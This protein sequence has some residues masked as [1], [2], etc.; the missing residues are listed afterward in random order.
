AGKAVADRAVKVVKIPYEYA[1]SMLQREIDIHSF[2]RVSHGGDYHPNIVRLDYVLEE[3][4]VFTLVMAAAAAREA[5]LEVELAT[6]DNEHQNHQRWLEQ[7]VADLDHFA[8]KHPQTNNSRN[9]DPTA[10]PVC[11]LAE[12]EL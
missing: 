7:C 6:R 11:L 10:C 2:L 1:R 12:Q 8:S 4:E 3:P 5:G 9:Q